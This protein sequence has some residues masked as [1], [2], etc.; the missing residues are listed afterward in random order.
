MKNII[1]Y[2]EESLL[3][4]VAIELKDTD[5]IYEKFG[6]YNGCNDLS[7]YIYNKLKENDF[8]SIEVVYDDVKNIENIVFDTLYVMFEESKDNEINYLIPSKYDKQFLIDNGF[9]DN[10]EEY[11]VI[12]KDTNR[13]KYCLIILRTTS[14]RNTKIKSSLNHELNH[15]YVDYKL[16]LQGL[17]SFI[18]LFDN[19]SYKRTKEYNQHKHPF[20]ARQLEN[21]L[22]LLN[23]YEKNAFIS[24]LC[25][26]IRELKKSDAYYKNNKLDANLMFDIIKTLDIYKAYMNIANFIND[27]DNDAL[28][29]KEKEIIIDEWSKIYG[30]NLT[31]DQIFKK[32]KQKF[33]K[34]KQKIESII[35]K[36]IAEEYG[37]YSNA[38]I[39]DEGINLSDPSIII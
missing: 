11:S 31:L 27:Y 38:V 14:F 30:E 37:L 35:P 39:M 17:K 20:K 26:E 2:L 1:R 19:V 32:L 34:T 33:I 16:Q 8:N 13:F 4:H 5:I 10:Y 28:T 21:A 24:Q 6:E 23:A 9:N 25:S 7:E 29:R 3:K 18:E 12:N 36:K 15:M 22:Y